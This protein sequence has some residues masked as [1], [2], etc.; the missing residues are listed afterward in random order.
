[1]QSTHACALPQYIYTTV[2]VIPTTAWWFLWRLV[3]LF[4]ILTNLV[5]L[6]P[7]LALQEVNHGYKYPT[8]PP[9]D[10][11]PEVSLLTVTSFAR[12]KNVSRLWFS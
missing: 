11:C 10:P 2:H 3:S 7:C 8:F 1:M 5:V 4:L 12:L 9:V 6:L